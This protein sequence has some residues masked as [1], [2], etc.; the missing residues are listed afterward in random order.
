MR[1]QWQKAPLI[2]TSLGDVAPVVQGD[3]LTL[4]HSKKWDPPCAITTIA[5]EDPELV[6]IHVHAVLRDRDIRQGWYYYYSQGSRILRLTW[7]K[8][9]GELRG[10]I[11]EN[12]PC[13][14]RDPS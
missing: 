4:Y 3:T 2:I 7:S 1:L 11:E 13:Y 10:I 12:K 14:A 5:L 6:A 9:P 8:L